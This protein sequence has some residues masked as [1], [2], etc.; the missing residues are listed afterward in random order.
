MKPIDPP[1]KSA[2]ICIVGGGA[3]GIELATRLGR[4]R[5]RHGAE[6]ILVDRNAQHV[7]KPRLHEVAAGLMEADDAVGYLGHAAAHGYHFHMGTLLGIDPLRHSLRISGISSQID[8]TQIVGEREIGYDFLVLAL[9]SRANDFGI[10]GVVEHCHML[11]SAAEASGFQ[12]RFLESVIQVAEGRKERLGVG[13]AGAGATGVELAA[14]LR[15]A[16]HDL[17][18]FGGLDDRQRL[19][20]TL[21]DGAGRILPGLDGRTSQAIAKRM[22][23]F[24]VKMVLGQQVDHVTAGAFHLKNGEVVPC[25]LKVWAS[26]IIIQDLS[27]ILP[28][29]TL[30]KSGRIKVEDD[31]ACTGVADIFAL[32]DCAAALS[33]AGTAPPTAQVAHQQ[34]GYLARALPRRLQG[35]PVKP[36]RYKSRGTLISLGN[37]Q[38]VGE[39]PVAHH[40]AP[41][42]ITGTKTKFLYIALYQMHRAVLFGWPR[43]VALMIADWL[44]RRTLPPIKLHW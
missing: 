43:T 6:I 40:R 27:A 25:D 35:K 34:A 29:L 30:L 10:P 42:T 44:R 15:H 38:A 11:D 26:G 14:E 17:Q 5:G 22:T 21:V 12:R 41:L 39:I 19:D 31:L 37:K 9:G 8:R 3:G 2:R 24:G 1:S 32:G 20:I 16:S 36:F 7:W 18:R 13:I 23:Q 33:D 4:T 28:A